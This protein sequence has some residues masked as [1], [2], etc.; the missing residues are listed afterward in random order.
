MKVLHWLISI[1]TITF[2]FFAFSPTKGFA[3]SCVPLGTVQEGVEGSSAVFSGKVV[4][5]VDPNQNKKIQ[6]S[7]DLVEVK[8]AVDQ[9]WKG[10]N[11]SELIV[12]TERDSASCGFN[13]SLN[14]EY[15]VYANEVDGQLRV[16]LC[17]RTAE[18]AAATEDLKELGEGEKPAKES[19]PDGKEVKKSETV[20]K[21]GNQVNPDK[22]D[23]V[24][25]R[26]IIFTSLGIGLAVGMVV[27]FI[28][29][30]KKR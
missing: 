15:I 6:S 3:C 27:A 25:Q 24:N 11:Q 13:F 7:A 30:N 8:I 20:E 29:R 14:E 16:N 22:Q 17:S 4:E 12:Y 19:S 2:I 26:Y 10:S 18:L 5:I 9:S 21:L 28:M 23:N 1:V